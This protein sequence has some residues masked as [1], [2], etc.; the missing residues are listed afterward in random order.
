MFAKIFSQIYDGTLGGDW[1]ALVTFQQMLVLSDESGI[2]DMTP[3]AIHRVTGIPLDIIEHGVAKLAEPDPHSRSDAHEGRRIVLLD[4][5]RPW[6]WTVV[7][8]RYYRDLANREDKRRK[9]RERIAEK[10]EKSSKSDMSQAVAGCS[11]TSPKVADVAHTNTNTNTNTNKSIVGVAPQP[12]SDLVKKSKTNING[13]TAQAIEVLDFLNAKTRRK[14]RALDG[15]GKPTTNLRLVID[16]LKTGV[17]VQ[18]CKT[19]IARK[20]RDWSGDDKM[21]IYLRP[22]TLFRASNFEQYLGECV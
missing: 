20:H 15:N 7:N 11:G 10:R 4:P 6:G 1:K 21:R 17:S 12:P 22:S 19:M 2:I 8:K 9:D 18:D 5:D 3:A 16:R 13:H 14:Y